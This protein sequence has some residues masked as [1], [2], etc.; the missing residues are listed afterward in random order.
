[1]T[2]LGHENVT[3]GNVQDMRSAEMKETLPAWS[4]QRKE[5]EKITPGLIFEA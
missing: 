2:T 1:M 4:V 3:R 5:P